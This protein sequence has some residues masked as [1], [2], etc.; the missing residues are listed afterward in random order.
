MGG[1]HPAAMYPVIIDPRGCGPACALPSSAIV[2]KGR[3]TCTT[4]ILHEDWEILT[5]SPT[6]SSRAEPAR[7]VGP[8]ATR[9]AACRSVCLNRTVPTWVNCATNEIS[10]TVRRV[11]GALRARA[12]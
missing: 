11:A 4:P 5:L 2:I 3:G 1:S 10:N 6:V 7:C 8:R 12:T 9:V